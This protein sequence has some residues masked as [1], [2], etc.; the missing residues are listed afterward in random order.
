MN[1]EAQKT[2]YE[3]LKQKYDELFDDAAKIEAFD[4]I[5]EKY[6]FGNFG[7]TAKAD[8]DVLMFSLYIDRILEND[9]EKYSEYSDYTLSKRFGIT[10]TK[11]SNLKVRKELLYPYEGFVWQ[12]SFLRVAENAVFE[13][14]KIKLMIP[15]KNLYLEVKNAIESA[16]GYIETQ[17]TPNLLQVN[18]E[19]FL[20]L[21]IAID[22]ENDRDELRRQ[23]KEKTEAQL[24]DVDI[25]EREPFG[26]AL[27]KQSPE[28]LI[29][30]IS[31]C[32][33][34]FGPIAGRI[35]QALV[36]AIKR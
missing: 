17:L 4:A 30:I 18:V 22:D 25:I 27:L 12:E 23:I 15:D 20:D 28:L 11:I 34:I 13:G 7:T 3:E 14:R 9:Q 6:Y 33:P 26:K 29:R 36:N 24:E 2:R 1:D 16:G 31:D 21:L 35:A 32:V 19:Y 10:Q 8:L 5:A